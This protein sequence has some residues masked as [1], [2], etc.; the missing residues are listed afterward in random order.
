MTIIMSMSMSTDTV[1][2]GTGSGAEGDVVGR[3]VAGY[4]SGLMD[5][6]T[7]VKVR[8][9]FSLSNSRTKD[10]ELSTGEDGFR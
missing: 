3:A 7:V 8:Y 9:D 2:T 10:S 1:I 6:T 5:E 4:G